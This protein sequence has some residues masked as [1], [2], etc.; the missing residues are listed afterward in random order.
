M[1]LRGVVE[2]ENQLVQVSPALMN[3]QGIRSII[4]H[5][6]SVVNRITSMSKFDDKQVYNL[7]MAFSEALRIDLML[8]R[9]RYEITNP[10]ARY[11]IAFE[12]KMC[13]YASL[14][15]A[16]EQGERL[17]LKSSH[18][19]V[20]SRVDSQKKGGSLFQRMVGWTGG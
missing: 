2:H 7:I 10:S 4:G 14:Q 1:T 11:K 19:E 17:F 8:N 5:V 6:E 12:A 9:V 13:A 3:E 16:H 20:T 15:K 18:Q